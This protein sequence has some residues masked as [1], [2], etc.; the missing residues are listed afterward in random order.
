MNAMSCSQFQEVVDGWLEGQRSAESEAHLNGCAEC[1][2]LIEDFAAIQAA[3]PPLAALDG[4]P[5]DRVWLAL[6]A[7][8]VNEGLIR[9]PASIKSRGLAAWI[10]ELFEAVPRPAIAGAYIAALVTLSLTLG[11][12]LQNHFRQRPVENP[13]APLSAQLDSVEQDAMAS[14]SDSN[15][16]VTASLQSNL[17]IL[18]KDISMCEKGLQENPDDEASRDYLY[19]AYQE[20]ADLL[21]QISERGAFGQ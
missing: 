2:A 10:E 17:A 15:P 12:P 16:A 9:E 8:L 18:D 3:A 5:P 1:R 4:A 6:R 14:L 20:K 19:E 13:A 7:D 11:G 21:A